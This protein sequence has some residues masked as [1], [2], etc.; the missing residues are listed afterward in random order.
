[1]KK[2]GFGN[3]RFRSYRGTIL[4]LDPQNVG[5]RFSMNKNNA[6]KAEVEQYIV[7]T[8]L[9]QEKMNEDQRETTVLRA[10]TDAVLMDIMQMLKTGSGARDQD[11]E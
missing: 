10:E 6:F 1:M 11:A 9:L 2:N 3:Y 4:S 7:Q 8:K 5:L